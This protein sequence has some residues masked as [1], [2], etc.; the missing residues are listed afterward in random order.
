MHAL[1]LNPPA[2]E[3]GWFDA[4]APLEMALV[5]GALRAADCTV[6]VLD[7]EARPL[8]FAE[9]ERWVA[10]RDYDL[11]YTAGTNEQSDYLRWFS[12]VSAEVR[13]W[14]PF[15]IGGDAAISMREKLLRY[16]LAHALVVGEPEPALA[17]VVGALRQ[18][19]ALAQ[20]PGLIVRE[21]DQIV[22]TPHAEPPEGLSGMAAAAW[23]L[24]PVDA[25]LH[26]RYR[27]G[28]RHVTK[29]LPVL[30]GRGCPFAC[31]HCLQR[32]GSRLRFRGLDQVMAEVDA[33]H[34]RLGVTHVMF[35][36]LAVPADDA[37]S[38]GLA[39]R[40]SQRPH[41]SWELRTRADL[42]TPQRVRQFKAAGCIFMEYEPEV[43][44]LGEDA[45]IGRDLNQERLRQVLQVHSQE[46][47][48][49]A[50][51]RLIGVRTS[52]PAPPP[53][54]RRPPLPAEAPVA[55][56]RALLPA[57]APMLIR[58]YPGTAL[59][60]KLISMYK[61]PREDTIESYF[62]SPLEAELDALQV[63]ELHYRADKFPARARKL[64]R[65]G[66][67]ARVAVIGAA[68]P[69]STVI[70]LARVQSEYPEA[71]FL[72]VVSP[73]AATAI[74][75]PQAR[76]VR[77]VNYGDVGR[78][79][80]LR[81]VRRMRPDLVVIATDETSGLYSKGKALALLSQARRRL[82]YDA[83]TGETVGLARELWREAG[84]R[85]RRGLAQ[86]AAAA[87]NL[88]LGANGTRPR[89][90]RSHTAVGRQSR[91]AARRSPLYMLTERTFPEVAHEEERL[92]HLARYEF[93]QRF[94]GPGD[95]VLDCACG[96]G[97]GAALLAEAGASVI[98]V[99]LS[100]TAIRYANWRYGRQGLSFLCGDAAR[101]PFPDSSFDVAVSFETIEHIHDDEGF[102]SEM[103]RVLKPNGALVVSTPWQPWF[104]P[105]WPYHVREYTRPQYEALLRKRFFVR[106]FVP[107]VDS[108]VNWRL[109][110]G[111]Y[112]IAICEN[113]K[114]GGFTITPGRW[115]RLRPQVSVIMCTWNAGAYLEEALQSIF[116]QTFQDFEFLVADNNSTDGTRERLRELRD[117]GKLRLIALDENLGVS[118]AL[119]VALAHS[120][121][122]FIARMDADDRS[123][124]E[125]LARQ[126]EFLTT[127]PNVYVLGTG[128]CFIDSEGKHTARRWT[129]MCSHEE[130]AKALEWTCPITHPS[131]MFRR[132]L[133]RETGPY[134]LDFDEAED[135]E[136]W[137]RVY[138]Q[139]T[140]EA[141]DEQLLEFRYHDKQAT[142]QR[143]RA[144]AAWGKCV[145]WAY[146][147]RNVPG[148]KRWHGGG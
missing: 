62:P 47:M 104:G 39:S 66:R 78:L 148:G 60:R 30:L 16:S 24:F 147:R 26:R 55:E 57:S 133:L 117:Q 22:V 36:G 120:R 17:A 43:L 13:P 67:G 37:V 85:L 31:G 93:A 79:G 61:E 131:V 95:R 140:M 98:G 145:Q 136:L 90:V 29:A 87:A 121:G 75:W 115:S 89:R 141:L 84:T 135:Y 122:R 33:L 130:I 83:V 74:S 132:E 128:S 21:R 88:L 108:V 54:E 111:N 46:R 25:Y 146:R 15:L 142:R 8:S 94:V 35:R 99:D 11:I 18:G 6:E 103:S 40:M 59:Y 129:T 52:V 86:R 81:E 14:A 10:G 34:E 51:K 71:Q 50:L 143:K 124:P 107:Q 77:V 123:R 127:H 19:S 49:L 27:R 44:E 110:L 32:E 42:M 100:P 138:R 76:Q 23:D 106:D 28:P 134:D 41:L 96:V 45:E 65:L 114:S 105:K 118:R 63:V 80:L 82:V 70:A 3:G 109:P 2:R 68:K 1:L 92:L 4:S 137:T 113:A 119:V 139:R 9:V 73:A 48:P 126:V 144:V 12:R 64:P 5:A 97:Y 56:V 38:A 112:M 101:L 53:A 69:S 116:D 7:L 102:L 91:T 125:R 72:V 20:V 58:A